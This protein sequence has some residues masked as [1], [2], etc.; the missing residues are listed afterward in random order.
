MTR[1]K[2]VAAAL[3]VFFIVLAAVTYIKIINEIRN[4]PIAVVDLEQIADGTYAGEYDTGLIKAQVKVEVVEHKIT[5]IEIV[6]H[7]SGWGGDAVNITNSIIA[8]Q[9][10]QVDAISGAT[11]S[12]KVILKAVEVALL[13]D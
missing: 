3:A 1:K 4:L 12:S 8:A 9:S 2:K 10:L 13:G 5:E 7:I 11:L 6:E